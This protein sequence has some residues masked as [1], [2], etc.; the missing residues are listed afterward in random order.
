MRGRPQRPERRGHPQHLGSSEWAAGPQDSVCQDYCVPS[1][2]RPANMPL[3]ETMRRVLAFPPDTKL[4]WK[5]HDS[6]IQQRTAIEESRRDKTNNHH[7]GGG[8]GDNNNNKRS[9]NK[10]QHQQ[11]QQQQGAAAADEHRSPTNS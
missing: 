4:E 2:F 6:S 9:S 1:F 3:S 8:G 5:S 11:Y 10:Q 7:H